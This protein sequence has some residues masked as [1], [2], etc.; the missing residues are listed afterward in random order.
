[1]KFCECMF[2]SEDKDRPIKIVYENDGMIEINDCTIEYTRRLSPME[3][4]NLLRDMFGT[5]NVGMLDCSDMSD[6]EISK[7]EEYLSEEIQW[8]I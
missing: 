2:V 6:E 5:T 7:I 3:S 1:M 4:S 8:N